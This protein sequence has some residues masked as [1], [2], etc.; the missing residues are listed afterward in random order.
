MRIGFPS[1]P[2]Y[3]I[4]FASTD[5]LRVNI[6]RMEKMGAF[7]GDIGVDF[8]R[9]PSKMFPN[10]F[11]KGVGQQPDMKVKSMDAVQS[12]VIAI[13]ELGAY[14]KSLDIRIGVHASE[15]VNPI[16]QNP[17]V[18]EQS[19]KEVEV[20]AAFCEY[21]GDGFV[22]TRIGPVGKRA[23]VSCV[24]EFQ[25]F[26]NSLSKRAQKFLVLENDP[27][28]QFYG[29]IYEVATASQVCGVP[30]VFDLGNF[31]LNALEKKGKIVEAITLAA[32][33]WKD[34][35]I[36]INYENYNPAHVNLEELNAEY[37]WKF[38]DMVKTCKGVE[39]VDVML[40]TKGREFD[41]VRAREYA[42]KHDIK[43]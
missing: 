42:S 33:T 20:L 12:C 7:M 35:R 41:V 19:A 37:F 38:I 11:M 22:E 8:Y 23:R 5:D 30:I 28:E 15:F 40:E 14:Y 2:I 26:W 16:S 27:R 6:A 21:F 32:A 4:A 1:R 3:D 29:T 18:V 10:V 17:K 24:G 25:N 43:Y 34:G 39:D 9:F 13:N 31:L 36:V